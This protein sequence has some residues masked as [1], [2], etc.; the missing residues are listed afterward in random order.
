[1]NNHKVSILTPTW[2]R[3]EYLD[4]V[5]NGIRLQSYANIEWIIA[6]DGSN[7]NTLTKLIK[8]KEEALFPIIII[9][10]NLRLGKAVMDNLLIENSTGDFI[11][12]CDSD[13]YLLPNS[14]SYLISLWN[15]LENNESSQYLGV[16]GMCSSISGE[17]QSVHY[18]LEDIAEITWEEISNINIRRK[19]GDNSILIRKN[20]LQNHKFL[21]VDFM[22]TESSYWLKYMK[23][24]MIYTSEIIKI[25]DRNANNRLSYSGKMDYCRGKAYSIPICESYKK[26]NADDLFYKIKNYI[27]YHR[28]CLHGDINFVKSYNIW[29]NKNKFIFLITYPIGLLFA[30]KDIMQKKVVKT[31][32]DFDKNIK[33]RNIQII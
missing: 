9:N 7:D 26:E 17:L 16:I 19:Y 18:K 27:N 22:I 2:N 12:W 21:E 24:K 6:N 8:F 1:M 31:H 3:E 33:N 25:V 30:V 10:S 23:M 13:D 15:K 28:Y 11:I 4:R 29:I 5:Y 14:I 32:I 20:I